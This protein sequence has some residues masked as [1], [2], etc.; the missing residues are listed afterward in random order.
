MNNALDRTYTNYEVARNYQRKLEA[1]GLDARIYEAY[2]W[3]A[4]KQEYVV[5][6]KEA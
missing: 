4:Q 5:R 2:N 6:V 1:K 3:Q